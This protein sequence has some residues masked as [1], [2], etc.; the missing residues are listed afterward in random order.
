M[1]FELRKNHLLSRYLEEDF[2]ETLGIERPDLAQLEKMFPM[3]PYSGHVPKGRNSTS[4]R[5]SRAREHRDSFAGDNRSQAS[6]VPTHSKDSKGMSERTNSKSNT[7]RRM[8]SKRFVR[9][10]GGVEKQEK[11]PPP[12]RGYARRKARIDLAA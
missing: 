1:I 2:F 6:H 12:G 3:L 5:S 4:R 8:S 11:E 9:G 10:A 7:H